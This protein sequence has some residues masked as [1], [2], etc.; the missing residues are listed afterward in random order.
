MNDYVPNKEFIS[1]PIM[2]LQYHIYKGLFADCP[3]SVPKVLID[4]AT[5]FSSRK[6]NSLRAF[7][8]CDIMDPQRMEYANEMLQQGKMTRSRRLLWIIIGIV[9]G[10]I[11]VIVAYIALASLNR[12]ST[13]P[14]I[15]VP[16]NTIR[17]SSL[18]ETVT[19][20]FIDVSDTATL[21]S[22]TSRPQISR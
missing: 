7:S 13:Y 20:V 17:S 10:V 6:K 18:T 5:I 4:V 19:N 14:Y 3:Q 21:Y 9:V 1:P 12:S 2:V 11:L 16:E 15:R 8:W 22:V